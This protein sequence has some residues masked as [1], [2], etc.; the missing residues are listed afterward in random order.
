MSNAR[1]ATTCWIVVSIVG[2]GGCTAE[3][4]HGLEESEA[5]RV[6]AALQDRGIPA[7]TRAEGR[8]DERTWI[9]VV[10]A[11]DR[12]RSIMALQEL[13]LPGTPASGLAEVF[14]RG[15]L[16]PTPTEEQASLVRAIQGELVATLESVD[17]IIAA[18]VHV[19]LPSPRHGLIP[20]EQEEPI[21][22]SVLIRYSTSTPPLTEEQVRRLVAGAVSDLD[23]S[24]VTVVSIR[25]SRDPDARSCQLTPFGPFSVSRS[26]LA[27]LRIW[28]GLTTAAAGILGAAVVFLTIRLW[29]LRSRGPASKDA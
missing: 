10:P 4:S 12:A 18:R 22:A 9:V 29:R 8:Q 7:E 24:R 1:R 17:G 25:R 11:A 5:N 14:D 6:V 19:S 26:S 16:L 21:T 28:I 3:V 27:P 23:P 2:L 20:A 13:E 15:G